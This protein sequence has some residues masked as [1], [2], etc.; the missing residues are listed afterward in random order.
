MMLVKEEYLRS[1]EE[2]VPS[3]TTPKLTSEQFQHEEQLMGKSLLSLVILVGTGCF[4]LNMIF[5][6]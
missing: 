5:P 6:I 2:L 1:K 4:L 3:S